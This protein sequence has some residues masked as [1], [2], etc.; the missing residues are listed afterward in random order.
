MPSP[1]T[2]FWHIQPAGFDIQQL[3]TGSPLLP[4]DQITGPLADTLKVTCEASNGIA[5]QDVP[6]ERTI[7]FEHLRPQQPQECD[8]AYEYGEFHMR[9]KP[10]MYSQYFLI[11][12]IKTFHCLILHRI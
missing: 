11:F 9:C 10:G 8:L 7:S 2:F 6:C 12:F 1:D 5:S 3:T 4:L